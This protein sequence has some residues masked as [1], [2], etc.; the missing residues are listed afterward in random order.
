M[1]PARVVLMTD[2][3]RMLRHC[4]PGAEIKN[5]PG[6]H[7]VRVLWNGL[8]YTNLPK[9]AHG[10]REGRAEIEVGYVLDMVQLFGIEACAKEQ[11]PALR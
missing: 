1:A 2:V 6:L 7:K 10:K 3:V 4:A 5:K 9:G 11:L 8:T